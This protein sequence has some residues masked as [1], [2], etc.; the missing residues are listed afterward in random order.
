MQS[1]FSPADEL[2][3]ILLQGTA[4]YRSDRLITPSNGEPLEDGDTVSAWGDLT[5]NGHTAT[6]GTEADQPTYTQSAINGKPGLTFDGSSDH[7]RADGAASAFTGDDKAWSLVAVCQLAAADTS[8]H[9]FLGL[10]NDGSG[11]PLLEFRYLGFTTQNWGIVTRDDAGTVVDKDTGVSG[12]TDPHVHVI[13]STGTAITWWLD[14]TKIF[15]G[16]S[17]NVGQRTLD[18]MS[19]GSRNRNN[20]INDEFFGD[21]AEVVP[22]GSALSD[23]EALRI[24]QYAASRYGLT[25]A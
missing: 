4:W 23:A 2:P 1:V 10:G 9:C 21:I 6:Q 12:D 22:F 16:E 3:P 7:L 18:I 14:N 11:T 20:S 19:I 13:V 25:L 5:G 17:F 24:S 8:I 15:D